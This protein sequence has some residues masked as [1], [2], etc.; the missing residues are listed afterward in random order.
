MLE[1]VGQNFL[2]WLGHGAFVRNIATCELCFYILAVD[3]PDVRGIMM[4]FLR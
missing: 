2:A 1:F 3:I 4:L